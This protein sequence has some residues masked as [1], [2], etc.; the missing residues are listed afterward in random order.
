MRGKTLMKFLM[1]EKKKSTNQF[2]SFLSISFLKYQR[3][4]RKIRNFLP[5]AWYTCTHLCTCISHH[6]TCGHLKNQAFLSYIWSVSKAFRPAPNSLPEQVSA[7]PFLSWGDFLASFTPA[8]WNQ[9]I[10]LLILGKSNQTAKS[11]ISVD[12]TIYIFSI[13]GVLSLTMYV[14]LN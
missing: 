6:K 12:K 2:F 13:K 14:A 3:A 5:L 9:K 11:T 7:S 1:R 10:V 8:I 4:E